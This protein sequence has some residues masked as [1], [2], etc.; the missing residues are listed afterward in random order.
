MFSVDHRSEMQSDFPLNKN[1]AEESEE[2]EE[3]AKGR[4]KLCRKRMKEGKSS[5]KS[6]SST[7][8]W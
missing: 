1:E 3:M 7:I 4:P 5:N 2:V 6:N 8:K